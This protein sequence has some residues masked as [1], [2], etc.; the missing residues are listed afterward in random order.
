MFTFAEPPGG[1]SDTTS[2]RAITDL[3]QFDY[4]SQVGVAPGVP[5]G[6]IFF[7]FENNE[8]VQLYNGNLLLTHPSS[9][10]YPLNGGGFRPEVRGKAA[11]VTH[12]MAVA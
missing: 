6:S 7:G 4:R 9:V 2:Y 10:S 3:E 5:E 12:P 11:S 1:S 8:N